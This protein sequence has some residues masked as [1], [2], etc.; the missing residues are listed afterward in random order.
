MAF[1]LSRY[2]SPVCKAL[3]IVVRNHAQL[4]H[5]MPPN[6]K[7]SH[8]FQELNTIL[9]IFRRNVSVFE[10][11][12]SIDLLLRQ[13]FNVPDVQMYVPGTDLRKIVVEKVV[14]SDNIVA[15][16]ERIADVI[17][18]APS[19]RCYTPI[20][21]LVLLAVQLPSFPAGLLQRVCVYVELH[22]SLC[23]AGTSRWFSFLNEVSIEE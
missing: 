5:Q 15:S 22:R 6:P 7:I 23:V 2:I 18:S 19:T 10:L 9:L 13:H 4:D 14:T 11:F 21:S 17:E 1:T 20:R 3:A 12:Q 8:R 16:W